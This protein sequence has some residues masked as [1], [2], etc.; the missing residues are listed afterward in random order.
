MS[1]TWPTLVSALSAAL[2]L[3]GCTTPAPLAA[4]PP[5]ADPGTLSCSSGPGPTVKPQAAPASVS[6]ILAHGSCRI[7][8]PPD[9]AT[10]TITVQMQALTA[11][12]ALDATG[13]KVDAVLAGL[14][15]KGLTQRD[16]HAGLLQ[17]T[18][19]NSP[20][21]SSITGVG[22]TKVTGYIASRAVSA[23]VHA[24]TTSAP[25]IQGVT[26]S[27]GDSGSAQVSYSTSDEIALRAR[28]RTAAI[29]QAQDIAQQ[30][31][32]TAGVAL[33]QV[34]SVTDVPEVPPAAPAP[35]TQPT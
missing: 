5:T 32:T 20:I 22:G 18:P 15:S 27:L 16:F 9:T 30:M 10:L 26:D 13:A 19:I 12:A 34:V 31:A 14:T 4:T 6:G 8:E 25:I 17:V 21:T 7:T 1:C 29:R 24:L 28:A 33:G 3:S 11:R 35:S 2:V 23:T